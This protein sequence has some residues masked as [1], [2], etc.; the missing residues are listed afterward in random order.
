[1]FMLIYLQHGTQFWIL[2]TVHE[3]IGKF[4]FPADMS[5]AFGLLSLHTKFRLLFSHNIHG[6]K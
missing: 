1:M 6:G 2:A 4:V 5:N 3:V